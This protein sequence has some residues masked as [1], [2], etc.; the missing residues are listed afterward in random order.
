VATQIRAHLV[1]N[2][3]LAI[4]EIMGLIGASECYVR[5]IKL[6]IAAECDA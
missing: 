2:P 5:R 4:H 6:Q 3:H 1:R